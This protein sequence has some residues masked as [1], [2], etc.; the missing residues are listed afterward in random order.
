MDAMT[1]DADDDGRIKH[2]VS[3]RRRTDLDAA[4][5]ANTASAVDLRER[6]RSRTRSFKNPAP[7]TML[8]ARHPARLSQDI[9]GE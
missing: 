2:L 1:F 3:T 4:E 7:A 8:S 5:R 9:A 6:P